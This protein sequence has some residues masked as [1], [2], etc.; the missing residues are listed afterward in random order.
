M[1][2]Y[3]GFITYNNGKDVKKPFVWARS[4]YQQETL[5][6]SRMMRKN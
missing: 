5:L 4:L 2:N 1:A 6:I 3:A